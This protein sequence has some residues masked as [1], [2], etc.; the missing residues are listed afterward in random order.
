MMVHAVLVREGCCKLWNVADVPPE[1]GPGLLFTAVSSTWDRTWPQ[2]VLCQCAYYY[3][4]QQ[5]V[6]KMVNES[7]FV[8]SYVEAREYLEGTSWK[9]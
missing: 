2:E 7:S 5:A 4:C 3:H 8:E 6:K 9:C 1:Q